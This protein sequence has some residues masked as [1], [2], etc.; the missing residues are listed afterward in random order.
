MEILHRIFGF[1]IMYLKNAAQGCEEG[2]AQRQ[3]TMPL[4][5]TPDSSGKPTDRPPKRGGRGLAADSWE[6]PK[7]EAQTMPY[8]KKTPQNPFRFVRF[9]IS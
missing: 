9:S 4:R 7:A 5:N 6:N 3:R 1:T 2:K 8:K